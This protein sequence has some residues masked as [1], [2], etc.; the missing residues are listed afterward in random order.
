MERKTVAV[1]NLGC[2]VNGYELD[3]M[4]QE[5]RADGYECVPFDERADVYV[6]NTCSVTNIADRKSRQMLHRAR[7]QNP[8]A[9]V[10]AVGCYVETDR[11]GVEADEAVDLIIGNNR[12]REIAGLIR[13]AVQQRE[14]KTLGGSTMADLTHA[15]AFESM[16]LTTPTHTRAYIKI[17]DGCNQ[18]C[19]YCI[20]PYARG[21][22]RSRNADEI[23][24]EVIGL[25]GMG[26]REVVLTGIHISSY[27]KERGENPEDALLGLLTRLQMAAGIERIRL[28]SLEP[29]IMTEHFVCGI[30]RLSKVCP[31]FHLSLQSGCDATLKRMNRHYTAAEY[32]EVTERL[33]RYYDRPAITTD[34]IVGF[35]GESEEDFEAS[36]SFVD[37]IDFYETHI[38]PFSP[39][40]GTPA[41]KM[42][43]QV[44]G[45]EKA[46]RSELLIQLSERK[47]AAYRTSFLG[48]EEELLIEEQL[49]AGDQ[50]TGGPAWYIGHT[51]RYVEGKIYGD[52]RPGTLARGVVKKMDGEGRLVLEAPLVAGAG[53]IE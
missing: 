34:V 51:R 31:H 21:R 53:K 10:V 29:R 44:P 37:S 49:E 41:E 47:S 3:V 42:P 30:A 40:R 50:M 45:Q 14:D 8:E 15:P 32:R 4:L 46:R 52:Y 28:G 6:I 2:K 22:I 1:H 33:R 12:K 38:F 17:Q 18:F 25:A 16:L 9:L 26:I 35:P 39:R 43:A 13:K 23:L 20:I 36:R 48:Q 24:S 7:K 5:L 11:E 27:G 19:T